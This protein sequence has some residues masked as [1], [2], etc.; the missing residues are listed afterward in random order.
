M[1]EFGHWLATKKSDEFN[2]NIVSCHVQSLG[3]IPATE[4]NAEQ[5][6]DG[7]IVL[8]VDRKS[9]NSSGGHNQGVIGSFHERDYAYEQWKAGSNAF[10][11]GATNREQTQNIATQVDGVIVNFFDS[12]FIKKLRVRTHNQKLLEL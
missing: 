5:Y 11:D 1:R 4:N 10:D 8:Y 2:P 9:I 7:A 6:I 3:W 12:S